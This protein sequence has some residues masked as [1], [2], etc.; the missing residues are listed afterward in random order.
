MSATNEIKT[1]AEFQQMVGQVPITV[2]ASFRGD[3]C[4]FCRN[5]LSELNEVLN[6]LPED[7]RL[8]GVSVDSQK[9]SAALQRKLGLN[10]DLLTD[11]QLVMH[12]AM[13]VKT[14]KLPGKAEY[15]QPSIFIYRDGQKV[16]EWI[17][18]PKLRNLGGAIHRLS[19]AEVVEAAAAAVRPA[20]KNAA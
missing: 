19:V 20:A 2:V 4:P 8:V 18:N 3:W 14:G 13:G 15:L 5:Y 17:Q 6:E 10:F 9:K 7:S 11:A 12:K 1:A 16:F